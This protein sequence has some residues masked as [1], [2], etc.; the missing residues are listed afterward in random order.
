[1]QCIYGLSDLSTH[2]TQ[3][4]HFVCAKKECILIHRRSDWKIEAKNTPRYYRS[5]MRRIGMG[6][7]MGMGI[8]WNMDC[9]YPESGMVWY[10]SDC[11]YIA[12]DKWNHI[13]I[14]LTYHYYSAVCCIQFISV[15]GAQYAPA[16]PTENEPRLCVSCRHRI[17]GIKSENI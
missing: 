12:M 2:C 13:K 15:H 5:W 7:G 4:F 16:N 3:W 14:V 11:V 1:M 8:D 10:P 17:E 6:M 9:M